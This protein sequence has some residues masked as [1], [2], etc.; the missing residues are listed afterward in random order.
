MTSCKLKQP[1][2]YRRANLNDRKIRDKNNAVQAEMSEKFGTK[3]TQIID[4]EAQLKRPSAL[5]EGRFCQRLL[6]RITICSYLYFHIIHSHEARSLWGR[7]SDG[8]N[9]LESLFYV[10][11][12]MCIYYKRGS[13]TREAENTIF[14]PQ[15]RFQFGM[16]VVRGGWRRQRW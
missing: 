11:L 7:S 10:L 5:N 16:V 3:V 12:L 1:K 14:M 8:I 15:R 2:N 4:T 13:K 6:P 9:D